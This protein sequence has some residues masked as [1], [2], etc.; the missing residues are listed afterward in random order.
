[1]KL[2]FLMLLFAPLLAFAQ[3]RSASGL[4]VGAMNKSVDPC[5]DFYQFA[6][7]NWIASNP[8]P[9][10]RAR[11]GRFT[12]LSSHNERILLDILQGAA[13]ATAKRS[14]LDTRIGDAFAA[15]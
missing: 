12:E 5:V 4:D 6:C 15:C 1:M 8:L 14:P 9:A 13:V 11:W 10:D 7:G 2:R 3:P